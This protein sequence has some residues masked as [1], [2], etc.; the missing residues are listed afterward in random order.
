SADR[1]IKFGIRCTEIG[2]K[3]GIDT[4]NA[5]PFERGE[6]IDHRVKAVF[7]AKLHAGLE[8]FLRTWIEVVLFLDDL[9]QDEASVVAQFAGILGDRLA[10]YEKLVVEFIVF[11]GDAQEFDGVAYILASILD[12]AGRCGFGKAELYLF[13]DPKLYRRRFV[14]DPRLRLGFGLSGR[15]FL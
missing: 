9:A 11:A 12:L 15:R 10:A 4:A 14:L 2:R 13:D 1:P 3:P 5:V 8:H 7:Q 6:I